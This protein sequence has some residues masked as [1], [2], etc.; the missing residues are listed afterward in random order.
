MSVAD[1]N[2]QER[3]I[4]EL[5][6]E[7]SID[8]AHVGVA[9]EDHVVTLTGNV[10]SYSQKIAAERAAAR[11]FGA[12]AIANDIEVV[13]P[14]SHRAGDTEIASAALEGLHRSVSVPKTGIDVT[15]S[16]GVVTLRG[17]VEWRYQRKAAEN[18]VRDLAGVMDVVNL[19]FV[20]PHASGELVKRNIESAL[21]RNAVLDARRI[22]VEIEGATV[23]LRGS[24][25]SLHE[26]REAERAAWA[27]PGARAV[28]NELVVR[29]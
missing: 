23:T 14:G 2:L 21:Q 6:W 22:E 25:H 12:Q 13:V 29:A 20:K 11:V 7:P 18:A 26:R 15:V 28:E 27:S 4:E 5:K 10:P 19:I 9:A 17:E 8:A 24:V 1:S 3:V 16:H